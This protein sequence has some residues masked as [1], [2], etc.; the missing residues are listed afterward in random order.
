M[1]EN[2]ITNVFVAPTKVK[3]PFSSVGEILFPM[4]AAC[5]EPRPGRKLHSGAAIAAPN[6]G[7]IIC[8]FVI[9]VSE[10]C[11]GIFGVVFIERINVDAPKRP[12]S[13]GRSG[14]FNRPELPSVN[15]MYPRVPE[16]KNMNMDF[17]L[18]FSKEIKRIEVKIKMYGIIF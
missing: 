5:P 10:I 16:S 11:F 4:T 15:V 3:K 14:S 18:C 12:V 8:F 1:N 2:P 17:I 6:R 9:V 7:L 13:N